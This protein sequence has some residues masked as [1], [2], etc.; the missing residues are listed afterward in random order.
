MIGNK[1]VIGVCLTK[2]H[3][4]CRAEWVNRL[5]TLSENAGCKM[6]V[7][8]SFVDFYNG[9]SFDEGAKSIY[10]IINYDIVDVLVVVCNSFHNNAIIG[11]IITE[12]KVCGKPVIV[13]GGTAEGC[14]SVC[15]DYNDA[16]K[17][18][19]N[20]VI[21]DHNVKDIFFIAGN[22]ISSDKD[23][24]T[25]INCFREVLEE[26]GI[27]F[28]K[29]KIAYGQYWEGPVKEIISDLVKDGKK[30]PQ[31]IFCANDYMA[32]AACK[33]LKKMVTPF[34]RMLS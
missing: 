33:E 7:F 11:D 31:A 8:N 18:M 23:S 13:V 3:D 21:K 6:L 4:I 15:S 14:W 24:V 25:R 17:G 29:D 12:A 28:D 16:F 5:H 20:H 19:M 30:P 34:L 22:D 10:G 26:N 9:D 27:P 2:I 1:K 32:F